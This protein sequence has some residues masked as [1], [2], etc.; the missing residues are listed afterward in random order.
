MTDNYRIDSSGRLFALLL[1]LYP[2]T[3]R[4][5]FAVSMR[6]VF[7]EQCREASRLKGSL[8]IL[9]L[10]LRTL[11]DLA[12]TAI[13][14]HLTAPGAAWGLMEPVPNAPLPWKGVVLILLPGMVYLV[15][16]VAQLTGQP[17]YLTVYYRAAFFL[18]LPPLVVWIITRRFPLWGLI[19]VGLLFRLLQ[20]IGYQL[21]TL[22]PGVFS[23]NPIL[24]TALDIARML[25]SNPFIASGLFAAAI[26]LLGWRHLRRSRPARGVWLWGGVYLAIALTQIM[27]SFRWIIPDN[28]AAYPAITQAD[29]WAYFWN[30]VGWSLY[31]HTALLLLVFLGTLFTRRH[32]MF[33]ILVLVGY[34]LPTL[35]IG[36]PWNLGDNGTSLIMI[37]AGILVFRGLL[38]LVLPVWMSRTPSQSGKRG[39]VIGLALAA[40]II[41][42]SMQFLPDL[43]YPAGVTMN[44]DWVVS[45]LLEEFKDFSALLLGLALYEQPA[46]PAAREETASQVNPS[47][48]VA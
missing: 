45:V 34:L 32:G 5:E 12:R 2:R 6:Q 41:H 11:P 48:E 28:L 33:S 38:S 23:S 22:H 26:V 44:I 15:S 27:L 13:L 9:F 39:V 46:V 4:D 17:W 47:A 36:T 30:S 29:A 37:F 40:L 10:W 3:H 1:N 21:V 24:N 20:E 25:E 31:T 42:G 19:P 43:F 35:V 16:Q 7:K 8:G 18:I 14:E